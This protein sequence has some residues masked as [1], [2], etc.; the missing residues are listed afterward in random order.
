MQVTCVALGGQPRSCRPNQGGK[1]NSASP[2]PLHWILHRLM[3][4]GLPRMWKEINATSDPKQAG[5]H[6]WHRTG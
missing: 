5:L 4:L 1:V 2:P 6:S 3:Q